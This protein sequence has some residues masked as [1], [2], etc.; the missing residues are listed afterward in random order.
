MIPG[1]AKLPYEERLRRLDL[2]SLVYR[3]TRKSEL[4]KREV[5]NG[6]NIAGTKSQISR[7]ISVF[8]DHLFGPTA[9]QVGKQFSEMKTNSYTFNSRKTGG[10]YAL[11]KT[12]CVVE[13]HNI[14]QLHN[15]ND[16]LLICKTFTTTDNFFLYPCEPRQVRI[17]KVSKLSIIFN[18]YPVS[19]ITCK[20]IVLPR[21]DYFVALPMLHG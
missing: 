13:I 20:C 11:F 14:I 21:K 12:G 2:P 3:R 10:R 5:E 6:A 7:N 8:K 4:D 19:D 17:Y 15:N 1:M 16:I 9:S 18:V